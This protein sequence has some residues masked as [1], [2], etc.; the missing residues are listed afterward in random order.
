M[1][2]GR[3]HVPCRQLQSLLTSRTRSYGEK[4]GEGKCLDSAAIFWLVPTCLFGGGVEG[5]EGHS[6]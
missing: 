1:I 2:R 3:G 4:A 5:T 6:E